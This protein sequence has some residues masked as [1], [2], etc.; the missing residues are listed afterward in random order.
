[1][2]GWL[3][4]RLLSVLESASAV[5]ARGRVRPAAGLSGNRLMS[6]PAPHTAPKE[7]QIGA[8][9]FEAP[10]AVSLFIT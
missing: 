2:E 10:G 8:G 1:M 6:E 7:L 4:R 5:G 9:S 3:G